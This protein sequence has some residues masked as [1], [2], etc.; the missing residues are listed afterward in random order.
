M[1]NYVQYVNIDFIIILHTFN[2]T[3]LLHSIEFI[4][5]EKK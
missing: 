3:I 1:N 2:H 4:I 5:M